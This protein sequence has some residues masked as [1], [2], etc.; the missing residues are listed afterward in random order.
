[1]KQLKQLLER[2]DYECIQGELNKEI[3]ELVYDSRKLTQNSLFVCVKGAVA[4]GH[5]FV[6]DAVEKGAAALV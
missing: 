2:M 4:D 1:M 6:A 5:R 3:S